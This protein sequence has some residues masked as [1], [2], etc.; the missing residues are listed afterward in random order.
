MTPQRG[1]ATLALVSG[2][3]VV[4]VLTAAALQRGL[5]FEQKASTNQYRALQAQE[6]AEAGL[7]W[8]LAQL[9]A[10]RIDDQCRPAADGASLRERGLK[11]VAA[12][13]GDFEPAFDAARSGAP[14]C[15]HSA[16]GWRCLCPAHGK[17][18]LPVAQDS[19][20][21]PGFAVELSGVEP[22]TTR[23]AGAVKLA[24][25]GCAHIASDSC[26]GG[27]M[28]EP[29]QAVATV[30]AALLPALA[31]LPAA[32][33]V[34]LGD[35]DLGADGAGLHNAD[36]ASGLLVH[37]GGALLNA[38][39]ARLSP[40]PGTPAASALAEHDEP[41]TG[42]TPD[43]LLQLHLG[44]PRTSFEHLPSVV[45]L[46]CTADCGNRLRDAAV[47]GMRMLRVAGDLVLHNIELG[48][49]REPVLLVADG[50]IRLGAG[51]RFTGVLFG[52]SLQWQAGSDG[53]DRLRGA[54]I[55]AGAVALS[56]RPDLVR[57]A[58]VLNLLHTRTGT[59][60]RVPGS[61]KDD[62]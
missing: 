51:V 60:V 24:V 36:A 35:V 56:G 34:A 20:L 62:L 38:D 32:P 33:L 40:P 31:V 1:A 18:M 11:Y 12:Q 25:R 3:L 19:E 22:G 42:R 5:V 39:R 45:T 29:G 41:L 6:A 9:N 43:R 14:A 15:R 53:R 59:F 26:A 37:A 52:R 44:L 30:Q 58:D 7:E 54:A 2:L 21:H 48:G 55:V 10:G 28:G 23:L 50:G 47:R 4:M 17:A 27:R 8:A 13:R 16:Q 46:D 49:P 61:W 57:D